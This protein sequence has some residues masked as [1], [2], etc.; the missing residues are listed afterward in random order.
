MQTELLFHLV[1]FGVINYSLPEYIQI[2]LKARLN[3]HMMGT[4]NL[5][6]NQGSPEKQNQ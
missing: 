1:E 6:I 2:L 5:F 3:G 4:I